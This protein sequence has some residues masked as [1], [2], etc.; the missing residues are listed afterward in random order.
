MNPELEQLI[1]ELADA[2][3]TD[4]QIDAALLELGV[5]LD[6]VTGAPTAKDRI[7]NSMMGALGPV[8]ALA[9]VARSS[10][11]GE[12]PAEELPNLAGA[13]G[14]GATLNVLGLLAGKGFRDKQRAFQEKYPEQ[15]TSAEVGGSL[16]LG[17]P[18]GAA[19]KAVSLPVAA[20]AAGAVA[21]AAGAEAG[22]RGEQ[23]LIGGGLGA[24]LGALPAA[25]QLAKRGSR[26]L[27]DWFKPSRSISREVAA[28]LP[29]DVAALAQHQNRLAPGSFQI[30][31][32]SPEAMK[33][34]RHI[35]YDREATARAIQHTRSAIKSARAGVRDLQT[36]YRAL[37]QL[38]PDVPLSPEM[39]R[40]M[41]PT[42]PAPLPTASFQQLQ[43]LRVRLRG[44]LTK[45]QKDV[46]APL[47][48][49]IKPRLEEVE[50]FMQ[51]NIPGLRELDADWKFLKHRP[52][53]KA[54]PDEYIGA[55]PRAQQLLKVLKGTGSAQATNRAAATDPVSPG[56]SLSKEG[57]LDKTLGA[58]FG[59]R[60]ARANAAQQMLTPPTRTI[61]PQIAA[62]ATALQSAASQPP[63]EGPSMATRALITGIAPRAKNLLW[64]QSL[65][66]QR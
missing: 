23:A 27:L 49:E 40:I 12:L 59:R 44:Q 5:K 65:D 32:A 38:Y 22:D 18:L 60:G 25:G 50:G 21:G 9:N 56:G 35:S 34:A 55:L 28:Q 8:G 66:K 47:V 31:A 54:D 46:N 43:A 51:T 52:G 30:A 20:G 1:A 39:Q 57:V 7:L 13:A 17:G 15:A 4:E 64:L 24:A 37:E 11:V 48:D 58:L 62:D 42:N 36:K 26:A 6:P 2:G 16:L 41:F 61:P 19:A 29:E 53:P 33:T 14:Q 10:R 45:A 3:L 63:R